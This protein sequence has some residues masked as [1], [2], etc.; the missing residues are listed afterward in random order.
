[1][2]NSLCLQRLA[3]LVFSGSLFVL[4]VSG[5][6]QN[7]AQGSGLATVT[8]EGVAFE[9]EIQ[10]AGT[11]LKLNG[12][13]IRTKFVFK[14]YAAGLYLQGPVST[15]ADVYAAKG[16]KRLKVSFVRETDATT[17]GKTMSQVMSDNLPREQFGKCIPG[18]AKLG[19]LF[20]EKKK[21]AVGESFT[22][23][24]IPGKGTVVSINNKV[25]AEIGEPE[26]FNCLMYNYFGDRPADAKLKA[27]LLGGS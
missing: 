23:D 27:G 13:G 21:M 11:T 8:V 25:A 14:I 22:V 1:M 16:P 10:L 18:I 19:E 7:A 9:K 17:L 5:R 15:S 26:F 24:D 12:A 3:L 6:A 4:P 2:L 20:A